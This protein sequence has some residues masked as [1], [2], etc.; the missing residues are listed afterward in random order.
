MLCI[1][2]IN[3][4]FLCLNLHSFPQ[5]HSESSRS[6]DVSSDG[7]GEEDDSPS[8]SPSSSHSC[9]RAEHSAPPS[10]SSAPGSLPIEGANFLSSTPA[11]WSVD[12]V[13]RFISSLQGWCTLIVKQICEH[14]LCFFFLFSFNFVVLFCVQVV[15]SWL[16][17]SCHR[18]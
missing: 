8:L 14:S 4:S 2:G 15:K 10:D 16:P 7:E 3:C 17:S 6:E 18:K 11:Q 12:E 13:C 9:S 5:C 1:L